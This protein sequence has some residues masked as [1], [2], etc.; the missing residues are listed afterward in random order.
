MPAARPAPETMPAGSGRLFIAK[1][2][3]G[4][5]D[6]YIPVA[7][8]STIW[9]LD[10]TSKPLIERRHFPESYCAWG[11]F[12]F[13]GKARM[14]LLPPKRNLDRAGRRLTA[15][16]HH[17]YS[18]TSNPMPITSTTNPAAVAAANDRSTLSMMPP[19]LPARHVSPMAAPSVRNL[20]RPCVLSCANGC[21]NWD[22]CGASLRPR[23]S[24]PLSGARKPA[25]L[26][27]ASI[28]RRRP[29][30][31]RAGF[32]VCRARANAAGRIRFAS[33]SGCRK[34][35]RLGSSG[36]GVAAQHL[37]LQ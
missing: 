9:Y 35:S 19:P 27:W 7:N 18:R 22:V 12:R 34:L 28:P 13:F 31:P 37:S 32:S 23:L 29:R 15:C 26:V 5:R 16:L 36:Y 20:A 1:D 3:H 2:R 14:R 21:R 4:S 8:P 24:P 30:S 11:C 33:L 25:L 17:P 6:S 10:T